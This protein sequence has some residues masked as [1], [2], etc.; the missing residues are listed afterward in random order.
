MKGTLIVLEGIDGSGKSTQYRRLCQ[1]MTALG[2]PFHSVVFPRYDQD[3]SALVRLYL[4]GAFGTKPDDVNAYAASAFYAV[5]RF[6][7][8]RL[9]WKPA[10]EAGGLILADRYTTSNACHQGS[11]LP[12]SELPAYFDWL[13]DFE[14]HRLELPRP[15]LVLYLDVELDVALAQMAER[16]RAGGGTGDIH[17][18]DAAYLGQCL[19][20]GRRAAAHYGWTR[21]AC[22]RDGKMRDIEDIHEEIF[23]HVLLATGA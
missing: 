4:S 22:L 11:K 13:Y 16:R 20:A 23:S 18:K 19:R 12:D 21:I 10:Y 17:E 2:K 14:Y 7:S 8:Y 15:D 9:D 6:A 3:S 1:H 5:D